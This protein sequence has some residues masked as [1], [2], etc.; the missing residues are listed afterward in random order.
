VMCVLT[1]IE[2]SSIQFAAA[3]GWALPFMQAA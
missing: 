2:R 1:H 3:S